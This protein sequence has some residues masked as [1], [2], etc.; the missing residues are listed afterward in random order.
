MSRSYVAHGLVSDA[1]GELRLRIDP[2]I[3]Y[4]IYRTFPHR[5]PARVEV[6]AGFIGGEASDVVRRMGLARM[7][8]SI[9]QLLAE[10]G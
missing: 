4:R 10:L 6:P 1:N 8:G 7:R 2:A 3:E 9:L 5:M